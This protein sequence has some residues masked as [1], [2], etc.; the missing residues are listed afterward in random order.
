MDIEISLE[1]LLS[2]SDADRIEQIK[3]RLDA[4]E[5]VTNEDAA[6]V[7]DMRW[8]LERVTDQRTHLARLNAELARYKQEQARRWHQE[9]D[10]LPYEEDDRR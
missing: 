7:D 6:L 9:R 4:A 1:E 5:I 3:L 10:Y 8:L 2:M